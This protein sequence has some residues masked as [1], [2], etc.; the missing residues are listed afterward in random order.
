MAQRIDV[1]RDSQDPMVESPLEASESVPGMSASGK[2]KEQESDS[3]LPSDGRQSWNKADVN[4]FAQTI[5]AMSTSTASLVE[6]HYQAHLDPNNSEFR[7]KDWAREYYNFRFQGGHTPRKAG[8]A[9]RSLNVC[10][11]GT[12]TDYQMS[13]GNAALK[14]V[15]AGAELLGLRK[16]QRVDILQDLDGLL[17]PGEQ[18]CVL[19]PPGS[20]C[21]TLLK[22]VAGETLGLEVQPESYINYH[23]ITPKQ[24]KSVFRGEAIYTAEVDCHF[25]SL[26]VGDTLYFAALARV[27]RT[28]PEGISRELYATHLRDV[29]MAMFGIIHTKDTQVGND[30]VRG[31]SGGERKRVTIAEASLS[32]AP[33]QCWDNSTRG[34]DSANAIEFCKTLRMQSDVFGIASCV[35]IYQAPQA[36]Y[37]VFDKV[38]VLYEGRQIYF[39]RT[40]DA[41][42]YFEQ[43][44]F[45]CPESQ[46]TP[47]FLTSMTSATERLISPGF[48]SLVPR[49]SVEFSQR[50]KESPERKQLLDQIHQYS[51]DHPF[52]GDNLRE[53]S[54]A[55]KAEKSNKQREDSPYTLSYGSQIHLCML[56]EM[57]RIKAELGIPIYML[58][59]NI[60]MFLVIGS[61]FY[62]LSLSTESFFGRGATIFMVVILNAL[63]TV[64][65]IINLYG[66]RDII[67]KHK[68]YALYHPSADSVASMVM[69]LPYKVVGA[70]VLNILLYFMTD[71]R[72]E[73]A[74]LTMSMFFRL[75]GSL[76]KTL[77]QAMTPTTVVNIGLVLYAGFAI[78][79]SYMLGWAH[80][81]RYINPIYYAFEALMVNEFHGRK[82][83]CSNFV[84]SGPGYEKVSADERV[85]SVIGST[86]GTNSVD[87]DAFL[88][89]SYGYSYNFRWADFGIMVGFCVFLC[90]CHLIAS[91]LVAAHRSKGEVLVF[92][93]GEIHQKLAKQR[94]VDDE[95]PRAGVCLGETTSSTLPSQG[96]EQQDSVFH[97]E[98]V[99]YDITVQKQSRRLLDNVD[100]WVKPGSLTALMGVSGAGKT[101]LLDV[102]ANRTTMGV[103]TGDML[104]DGRLRDNSFQR[105]TGYVQQQDLHLKTSTVREALE[106]SAL[107]RQPQHFTT[108]EKLEY[109]NTVIGILSMEEYADA[110]VGIPGSGL[111]V[112]QRKRLTIGVELVARPK[113]LIFLDEPTSGL[114]SQTSWSICNLMEKLT[115]NGQ[116]ILCTIHQ[117]SAMLFQRFDRLL[118]LARGGKTVYFGDIGKQSHVLMDYFVRNGGP[119]CPHGTNPAEHML[120]VIGAAPG[121]Q[122]QI[123][124]PDVWRKSPEYNAVCDDLAKLKQLTENSSTSPSTSDPSINTEF[125]VPLIGQFFIVSK[126]VFQDLWRSPSYIYSK[127]FLCLT[128]ALFIGFSFFNGE[129]TQQ[130]LQDQMIGVFMFIIVFIQLVMQIIPAYVSQR[131]LYEAR[132]RQSKTYA[133]QIFLLSNIL[134]ELFWNSLM[135]VLCFVCWYYPMGVWRN[136]LYAGALHSRGLLVV[137]TLW[138]GFLWSSSFAHLVISGFDFPEM[139]SGLCNFLMLMCLY[140]C[141]II[142][143]PASFPRFW[144]FMYRV[145]PM[146]YLS[147]AFISASLADAPMHCSES[148][149][150]SFMSPGNQSCEE[151]MA[152]YIA[153]AGG[154]LLNPDANGNAAE[155]CQYCA[156]GN[157]N[158]F[159][160]GVGID[161]S[162]R[163]R[164]FGILWVFFVFNIGLTLF[165]YWF[166][167]VSKTKKGK[168]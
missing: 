75:L 134:S 132:E 117:P 8:I 52:G 150:L 41:K 28:I 148:E 2:Q 164:D 58:V 151:Y 95:Q 12:A 91:E 85:C 63:G 48:E 36:A 79:A 38:T 1:D 54:N 25:P 83:D 141:G 71:L 94:K 143:K 114:D 39:G 156:V 87:G 126:R 162:T 92:R 72:R 142:A 136:A 89:Q 96:V 80:W 9:F 159:L 14:M 100:G 11:Y 56:R 138:A 16:K 144:I 137:L 6:S 123:D 64:L 82:F 115:N 67:E 18:L 21:S 109:V 29:T 53:F 10:G 118:L 130:G 160:S 50:W 116:A 60:I 135:A 120:T 86:P 140:F 157:T 146:T 103:V 62:N 43:L 69:D 68:R 42:A 106:F 139:A 88:T 153:S 7:A 113:L 24:M 105:N 30:F 110:V 133:W 168:Q 65:E 166:F 26:S 119:V 102:L 161:P 163:W 111:N 98:N 131:T 31:V 93:R 40:C 55:R 46:T 155:A 81:I 23:G 147:S 49:T 61:L 129:N 77:E 27:P 73:P 128:S 97:W 37:E 33:L 165:S 90:I 51:Q 34:L 145:S 17:L 112:E 57:T 108:Q 149:V 167:R 15:S 45:K 66:K 19:G 47:D 125:A 158:Q 44:G 127:I 152:P 99:C 5:K 124:W 20:G 101:T 13:V 76:T 74:Q 4:S 70:I 32:Y 22:T 35:A 121:S 154:F 84:P 59:N 107:L 104:V 122:T 78:P 3:T